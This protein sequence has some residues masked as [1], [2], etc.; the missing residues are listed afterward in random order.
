MRILAPV[1]TV[2]EVRP[3]LDAGA[4]ELYC[5]VLPSQWYEKYAHVASVNRSERRR[6][7]L[8]SFEELSQVVRIAHDRGVTVQI[9]L[10]GLYTAGQYPSLEQQVDEAVAAGVDAFIVADL[11]L[12]L[13]LQEM[14]PGPKVHVSTGG[15]TFNTQ[16][17]EFFRSLGA[18]RIVIPRQ[19][20]LREIA[21]LVEGLGD[22]E[23][24]VFLMNGGCRHI[25]GMCTFQHG[26]E[27]AS[28]LEFWGLTEKLNLGYRVLDV[29]RRAPPALVNAIDHKTDIFGVIAPCMTDFEIQPEPVGGASAAPGAGQA[30][31]T[32]PTGDFDLF[33]GL[34]TCGACALPTF[35]DLGV[36]S[37]KIVGRGYE[38]SKKVKDVTFLRM[39]RQHLIFE[40]PSNEE[41]H[42]WVKGLYKRLYKV[43]CRELCYYERED[44]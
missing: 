42:R 21:H 26:L 44:V 13:T 32:S 2:D 19:M 28:N 6:S 10:N 18:S 43:G 35:R 30:A 29:L 7:S 24:E 39:A 37:L 15:T 5:G 27:E 20:R 3:I 31:A 17:A 12:F 33:Y 36:D 16:T 11:G 14:N 22:M 1:N 23:S 34:D 4:D 38:T 25:T 41:F 40:D 9:T 8:G